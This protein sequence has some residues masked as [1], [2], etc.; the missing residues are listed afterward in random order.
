[1][2]KIYSLV[3]VLFAASNAESQ[4]VNTFSEF[5]VNPYAISPSNS[6]LNG[7]HEV[8]VNGLYHM[9]G[10]PGSPI[11]VSANYNGILK[12]NSGFGTKLNFEKFGAFRNIKLDASYA[13]HLKIAQLHKLSLGLA[14]QMNQNSVNYA[15]SNANPELDPALTS[16]NL[17]LGAVFN[18]GFGVSYTFKSFLLSAAIDNIIPYKRNNSLTIYSTVQT[19]RV[20]LSYDYAINRKWAIKPILVLEQTLNVSTNYSIILS[21]RYA[22]RVWLNVGYG[23]QNIFGFGLG[24]LIAQRLVLQYTFRYAAGGIV[25]S[26]AGNHELTLGILFG[27]VQ[28]NSTSSFKKITKS[29]YHD[30]E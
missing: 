2:H 12:G 15:N 19:I 27:K 10:V 26:S 1:M 11:S 30:W 14:F 4:F 20:G 25:K 6:G 23:A 29:P 24:S 3:L 17:R 8:F 28:S 13:Y 21:A 7:N 5:L 22:N 18:A 9:A 16:G